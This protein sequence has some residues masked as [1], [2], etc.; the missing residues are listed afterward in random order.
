M[1]ARITSGATDMPTVAAP[2]RMAIWISAG[3]SKDGPE[4][5]R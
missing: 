3:V 1:R 2:S 5:Q 4:Y